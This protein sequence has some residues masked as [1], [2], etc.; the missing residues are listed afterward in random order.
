MPLICQTK[1]YNIDG[2]ASAGVMYCGSSGR[3]CTVYRGLGLK[4]I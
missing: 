1:L 4:G 3:L 2:I